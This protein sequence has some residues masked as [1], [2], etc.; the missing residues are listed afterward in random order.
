MACEVLGTAG[1]AVCR[2][3]AQ[4]SYGQHPAL[5]WAQG[6]DGDQE[7]DL[8]SHSEKAQR[9]MSLTRGLMGSTLL[10][11]HLEKGEL[12]HSFIHQMFIEY[13]LCVGTVPGRGRWPDQNH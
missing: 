10:G 12:M 4:W 8:W 1:W 2:T 11:G 3:Q 13:L 9:A 7:K 6:P 5:C